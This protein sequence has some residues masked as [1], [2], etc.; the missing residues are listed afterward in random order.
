MSWRARF[1]SKCLHESSSLSLLCRLLA[2][3]I[4]VEV[5]AKVRRRIV[6][7]HLLVN[8]GDFLHI[9]VIELEVALEILLDA[10]G[11][12]ALGNDRVAVCNTSAVDYISS[13]RSI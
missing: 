13:P 10:A 4:R 3:K 1:G 2:L 8:A 9:V 5:P 6:E 12:L 11:C 7:P